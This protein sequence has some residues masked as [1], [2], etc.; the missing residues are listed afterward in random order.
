MIIAIVLLYSCA[1]T[2]KTISPERLNYTSNNLDDG[3]LF[4]YKY[5]ALFE[6]RNKKYAKHEEK[7]NIKLLAIKI[8]NNT[9]NKI[10]IVNDAIF[11]AGDKPIAPMASSVIID[12]LEQNTPI[13]LL[14]LLLFP[15]KLYVTESDG[16][17]TKQ[18]EIFP[19]GYIL[20]PGISIG[21]MLVASNANKNFRREIYNYDINRDIENGQTTFFLVGFRDIGYDPLTLRLK[22]K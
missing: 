6:S 19:I 7:E 12:E 4:S 9:G 3:I 17:V 8:T 14:Y 15:I 11:F 2:Y 16:F 22:K 13:Y 10:N 5:D 21:N 20:A 18:K 1:S